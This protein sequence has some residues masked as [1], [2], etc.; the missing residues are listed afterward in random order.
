MTIYGIEIVQ[1][2]SCELTRSQALTL[3]KNAVKND[4]GG[5]RT[6]EWNRLTVKEQAEHVRKIG[7]HTLECQD[8]NGSI[9]GSLN[10]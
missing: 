8:V 3:L 2:H 4:G 6:S 10:W 9:T 1:P 7:R 5:M